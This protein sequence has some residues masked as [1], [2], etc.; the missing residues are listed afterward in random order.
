[1]QAQFWGLPGEVLVAQVPVEVVYFDS[2][3]IV[4]AELNGKVAYFLLDTGAGVSILNRRDQ[5]EYA[6]RTSQAGHR[7]SLYGFGGGST[8]VQNA[9]LTRLT[10]GGH[11]LSH[12]WA[13]TD[14]DALFRRM[15]RHT[16]VKINGIIGADLMQAYGFV[17]DFSNRQVWM[18]GDHLPHLT[19]RN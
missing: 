2:K 13:A 14:L 18:K 6:F 4:A 3:P 17:I 7:T 19:Q 8:V 11:S 1:M 9:Y 15:E 16:Q 10:I 12:Q 5:K